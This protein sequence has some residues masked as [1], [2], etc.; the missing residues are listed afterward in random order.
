MLQD[1]PSFLP[2][3]PH[4]LLLLEGFHHALD[5]AYPRVLPAASGEHAKWAATRRNAILGNIATLMRRLVAVEAIAS[6]VVTSN[7]ST[8]SRGGGTGTAVLVPALGGLEWE[9]ALTG[10]WVLFRDFADDTTYRK[11]L[12]GGDWGKA[13]RFLGVTRLEGKAVSDEDGDV[14]IVVQFDIDETG[15]VDLAAADGII[16]QDVSTSLDIRR[17]SLPTRIASP[18]NEP[19][20]KRTYDEIA[21][22][23]SEGEY[24]WDDADGDN[25]IVTA[26]GLVDDDDD[27]FA[28][29]ASVVKET[30]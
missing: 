13:R 14:G 7:A 20:L 3:G 18:P 28:N 12:A 17:T 16:D 10:R 11:E 22:S 21:D 27:L 30:T 1:I 4:T 24:G 26:E 8:R 2:S 5:V 25:V 6:A 9:R 15:I 23:Q 19:S 29:G